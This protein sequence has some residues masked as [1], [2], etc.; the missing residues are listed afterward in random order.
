MSKLDP[1]FPVL[2]GNGYVEHSNLVVSP[3]ASIFS[4]CKY[5]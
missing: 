5:L 4:S 2:E 1:F 3:R